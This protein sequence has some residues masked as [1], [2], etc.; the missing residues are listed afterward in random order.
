MIEMK[1]NYHLKPE[2]VDS[3]VFI[4]FYNSCQIKHYYD[5]RNVLYLYCSV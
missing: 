5:D 2:N 3:R 1:I 4:M